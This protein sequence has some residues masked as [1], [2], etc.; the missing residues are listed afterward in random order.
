MYYMK[1]KHKIILVKFFILM[2]FIFTILFWISLIIFGKQAEFTEQYYFFEKVS[3]VVGIMHAVLGMVVFILMCKIDIR[4]ERTKPTKYK[5][6]TIDFGSLKQNI[7]MKLKEEKYTE[8]KV[9]QNS[10][11]KIH[12]SIKSKLNNQYIVSLFNLDE[13]TEEIYQEF[14]NNY[15]EEFDNY[16]IQNNEINPRKSL[17]LIYIIC[18]SKK[19]KVF[20]NYVQRNVYQGYQRYNLPIGIDL[21]NKTVYIATQSD[22]MAPNKH[23]KL[24]RMFEKYIQD[25][26][27]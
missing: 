25:I 9:Y 27:Q 4:P 17:N 7:Y 2:A 5:I 8:F 16:L 22:G 19:N 20:N 10:R 24:K 15:F 11:Y 13:L 1:N 21:E 3:I 23:R 6:N 14:K 26:K 18:V 12:Y